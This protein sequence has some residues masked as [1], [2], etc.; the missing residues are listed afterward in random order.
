MTETRTCTGVPQDLARKGRD[1]KVNKRNDGRY[2][3]VNM[4]RHKGATSGK[5]CQFAEGR[6]STQ[7][8]F[9]NTSPSVP[10]NL[11]IGMSDIQ[12][13]VLWNEFLIGGLLLPT[14]HGDFQL[15]FK[16]VHESNDIVTA[17][18]RRIPSNAI[19][20]IYKLSD[21]RTWRYIHFS[22]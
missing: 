8:D 11:P 17:F 5:K 12:H 7:K 10:N 15:S 18:K 21:C 3:D 4:R 2:D 9:V 1:R 16:S 13:P 6:V 20:D 22:T 19:D 14:S